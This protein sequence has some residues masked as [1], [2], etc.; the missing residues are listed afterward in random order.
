MIVMLWL[1]EARV[2]CGWRP[3]VVLSE[4]RKRVHVFQPATLV[5]LD[6]T[7]EE[8]RV[9]RATT[10]RALEAVRDIRPAKLA[11]YIKGRLKQNQGFGLHAPDGYAQQAIAVLGA[12][13]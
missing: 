9:A 13:G 8:Y 5:H 6:L 11:K 12:M 7:V 10:D 4:G 3:Y 2:G 1:D